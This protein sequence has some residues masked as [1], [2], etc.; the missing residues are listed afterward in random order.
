MRIVL[1]CVVA[2]LL[3]IF[4]QL[5]AAGDSVIRTAPGDATDFWSSEKMAAAH[6]LP[7]LNTN[8][9]DTSSSEGETSETT[10]INGVDTGDPTV[11]PNNVNGV[12]FGVFPGQGGYRCSGSI[13]DSSQGDTILTAGHCVID[14]GS[15]IHATNI[16]FVPGYR[17]GSQPYGE[18]D[19]L[20]FTVTSQWAA[21]APSSYPD[22]ASDV[23][24]LT[25]EEKS[26]DSIAEDIGSLPIKFY[27][28]R[29]QTYTAYGYPSD[30]PYDGSRLYSLTNPLA[31]S[32]PFFIPAPIAMTSDFTGGSSGGPWTDSSGNVVSINSYRYPSSPTMSSYMFG[33]YFGN[34]IAATYQDA[35][36]LF[37]PQQ[38]EDPPAEAAPATPAPPVTS[39]PP[40]GRAIGKAKVLGQKT[41]QRRGT[42]RLRVYIPAHGTVAIQ[43]WG[44]LTRSSK[45]VG[46]QR[47]VSLP[48]RVKAKK[49]LES[50]SR[51]GRLSTEYELIY[52]P[53]GAKTQVLNGRILLKKHVSS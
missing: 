34:M 36:D 47:V 1:A 20:A 12:V 30:S 24:F 46:G 2:C 51:R 37:V 8:P 38:A 27:S 32:D 6:P 49:E 53:A 29:N 43:G 26:G 19:A 14:A 41:N 33:P 31:M 48:I 40:K 17:L 15:G 21:T 23:A 22:Q 44:V 50:L 5:A 10:S 25:V 3:L 18:Y 13:V 9:L 45:N 16:I 7:L 39:V 52:R 28:S 35:S 4:P 42:A 11:Y